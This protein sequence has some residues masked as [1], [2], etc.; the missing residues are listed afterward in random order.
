MTSLI[1]LPLDLESI[2][3]SFEGAPPVASYAQSLPYEELSWQ[4]FERLCLRIAR[5]SIGIDGCRPYGTQGDDQ[6][7]IDLYGRKP[8][9]EKFVVVQCKNEKAFGPAKIA[10]AVDD[11]LRGDWVSRTELLILCMREG[12]TTA[13]REN[14]IHK[15]KDILTRLGIAFEPWDR[16]T[17]DEI[18]KNAPEIVSDFFGRAW[19][20][21]FNSASN[22]FESA[23]LARQ[24]W[25]QSYIDDFSR[26][27][28]H[29]ERI[30]GRD[31]LVRQIDS[32]LNDGSP[33]K[34]IWVHG[35]PGIGKTGLMERFVHTHPDCLRH[36]IWRMGGENDPKRCLQNLCAQVLSWLSFPNEKIPIDF[37]KMDADALGNTFASLLR[38]ASKD[39]IVYPR[40]LVVVVDAF[41]ELHFLEGRPIRHP[42][43]MMGDPPDGVFFVVSSREDLPFAVSPE[44]R[45]EIRRTDRGH[46]LSVH[47][48]IDQQTNENTI[49]AILEKSK[50]S[51]SQFVQDVKSRSEYN[52][53]Y[54]QCVFDELRQ[55]G[56]RIIEEIE[57]GDS[58][59]RSLDPHHLPIGLKG[60]YRDH[61]SRL[62]ERRGKSI[63]AFKALICLAQ[64]EDRKWSAELLAKITEIPPGDLCDMLLA[65]W[66]MFLDREAAEL[67][68]VFSFYHKT[69]WE[70]MEE[71]RIVNS[72]LE[73]YG[74][75]LDELLDQIRFGLIRHGVGD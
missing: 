35:E 46:Q 6:E 44:N 25:I 52:F 47:K 36:F 66:S 41:D 9:S 24:S 20:E 33:Q 28:A 51:V 16:L 37:D 26:R 2:P 21:R 31:D 8:N 71:D 67:E 3:S 57:T 53:M 32:L 40:K 72:T 38:Y 48:Y 43:S 55:L 22:C 68:R 27:V 4:N 23:Q 7:G 12:L 1:P 5:L 65:D 56:R 39:V 17:L 62:W 11:F 58:T 19:A 70:F 29:A 74:T 45:I 59:I 30:V 60:Y 50:I 34:T 75:S 10:A 63:A 54:L 73:F 64:V 61:W 18:L 13:A 42:L 15:Q 49:R 69:Y 14:E